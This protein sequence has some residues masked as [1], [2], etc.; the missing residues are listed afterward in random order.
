MAEEEEGAGLEPP[1][2]I[3]LDMA[4]ASSPSAPIV[5]NNLQATENKSSQSNDSHR[6]VSTHLLQ[7]SSASSKFFNRL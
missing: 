6:I 4:L 3:S 1:K 5:F 7:N 2:L